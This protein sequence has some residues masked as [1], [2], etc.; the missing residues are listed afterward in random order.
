MAER[1]A[2]DV[3]NAHEAAEL[4]KASD[5]GARDPRHAWQRW[6]LALIAVG[7]SLF[8]VYASYAG[9]INTQITGAIHLA[10]GFALAFLA[11]PRKKGRKDTIPW[12]DWLLAAAGVATSL[13]IVDNYY[14][15][16]AVQ[17]GVPTVRDVWVGSLLLAVLAIAAARIIGYALPAIAILAILYG[18]TGPAGVI[19]ATPP[20]L[21]QL[22]NGYSWQQIVQQL[23]I[24]EEGVWGT[25][26][27]VSATFVFLFVLFG[28]L[29]DK[30]GAGQYFVDLAYSGLGTFRG[31]PAKASVIASLLTGVISGS[32]VANVVTTGT[33]T[34]PLMKKAG[35]PAVKAGATECAS[36][37]NGQLMPPVMGAAAFIMAVFL[38][39]PYSQLIVY[40]IVPAVLTY[41]GLF[42]LVH[43]EALKLGLQG[44]PRAELPPFWP[45]FRRGFHYLLP[46]A[47]LL[48]E[49]MW[50]KLTPERSALN[51][52]FALIVLI[53][54]QEAIRGA[55][56]GTGPIAG[57]WNGVKLTFT[58]F[59]VGARNMTTIAVATAAAGII[60]GMVTMTNLGYGLTQIIGA[61]SGGN[62]WI[63]LVMAMITSLILGV[64]LPTTA[65]YIV[66]AAL[67]VPVIVNLSDAAGIAVPLVAVHMFVFY[68]GILADDTPPVGLAAYAAAAISRADPIATGIQGF[69]YDMRTAILPFMF[70]FNPQLLLYDVTSWW[71]QAGVLLTALIGM[72]AFVS[73]T[74]GYFTAKLGW[75][76]R[77]A[78]LAA[79]LL[80]IKPGSVSDLIGLALVAL[81][82]LV[83]RWR[84]VRSD[85]RP[86]GAPADG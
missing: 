52:T 72:L 75:P 63:V 47:F 16:V 22:H 30:A 68:F 27:R 83:N 4:V 5:H 86:P 45:T 84:T 39:I 38:D 71:T 11:F 33:F 53:L 44:V 9:T 48:Y 74:Q 29:L 3:A 81:V 41:V 28:S 67:V 57:L 18:V 69:V 50:V 36:S 40:A 7:W 25:P 10:F 61:V 12:Y 34:I 35:Y 66:M 76:E 24:T 55:R 85:H 60:V 8:Q 49:L 23:Y 79:A 58:G 15:I 77:A 37:V 19:H 14:D 13:Y 62:I 20:E 80:L 31:G 17:G 78:L 56:S 65:N 64:G 51:A 1:E 26:I 32:S 43:L 2:A 6:M 82:Y 59:E 73:A 46:V 70:F 42:Y 21:L 54:A